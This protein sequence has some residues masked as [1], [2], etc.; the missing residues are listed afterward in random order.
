VGLVLTMV[1]VAVLAGIDKR[2]EALLLQSMPSGGS[3]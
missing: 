3:T 2:I 1:G